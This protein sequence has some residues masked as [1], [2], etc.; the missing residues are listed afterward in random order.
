MRLLIAFIARGTSSSF[1][2]RANPNLNVAS[3]FHVSRIIPG[4]IVQTGD[5]EHKGTKREGNGGRSIYG[6]SFADEDLKK[7]GHDKAGILSM[8]NR[9]PHTN[10][11]QF[12]I[13]TDPEGA[14]WRKFESCCS[15]K[16]VSKKNSSH[17]DTDCFVS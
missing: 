12:M 8:A 10:S 1:E 14:D 3:P 7:L 4:Y 13:I 9:G 2:G 17:L 16:V 5:V 11:S 6:R 15:R